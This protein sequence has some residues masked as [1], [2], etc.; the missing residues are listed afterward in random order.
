MACFNLYQN[1]LHS[2]TARESKGERALDL[3][4]DNK[5]LGQIFEG[6]PWRLILPLK[7]KN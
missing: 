6:Q 4:T 2:C 3:E 1:V 7:K 5:K